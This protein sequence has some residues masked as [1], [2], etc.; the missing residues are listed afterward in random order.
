MPKKE[1]PAAAAKAA[2]ASGAGAQGVQTKT[3]TDSSAQPA[4]ASTDGQEAALKAATTALTGTTSSETNVA[5]PAGALGVDSIASASA[6]A[7]VHPGG[8]VMNIINI[9]QGG[10]DDLGEPGIMV[11]AR[12][13]GF[14]R[15]GR[16]WSMRPMAV[17]LSELTHEQLHMLAA[18]PNLRVRGVNITPDMDGDDK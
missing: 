7:D 14:R 8:Q 15:A 16:T 11:V 1:T 17:P 2:S 12:Y 6:G 10:E 4:G 9:D 5:A 3:S 13:E 18:D